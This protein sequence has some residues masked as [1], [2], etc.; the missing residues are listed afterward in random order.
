MAEAVGV[1]GSVAVSAPERGKIP[2]GAGMFVGGFNSKK[3]YRWYPQLVAKT[4]QIRD[5]RNSERMIDVPMLN[6]R[7]EPMMHLDPAAL[8]SC[9]Q[10]SD[11]QPDIDGKWSIPTTKPPEAKNEIKET[12][13]SLTSVVAELVRAQQNQMQMVTALIQ[14]KVP[15][16]EP[17]RRGRPPKAG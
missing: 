8:A 9:M 15:Q 3:E 5:P 16:A 12:L 4:T 1:N 13:T 6:E 7:G 2:G 10:M 17:K 14:G 11:N